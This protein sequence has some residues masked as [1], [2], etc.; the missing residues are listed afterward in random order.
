MAGPGCQA[1]FIN[2]SDI[3]KILAAE[4]VQFLLSGEE[5]VPLSSCDGKTT[6]LFF[7]ASWC[8][9]CTNSIPK[10]VELYHTL[11]E[12]REKMEILFISFDHNENEFKEHF[13]C[14]PWLAVPFDVNLNRRLSNRYQVKHIPSLIPL[15]SEEISAEKDWIG[16]I[17]DYGPEA[18]PF[19]KRRRE[20]LKACDAAMLEGGKLEDLLSHKGRNHVISNN[21]GQVL[22][23][24]LVGKTIGLYFG[25]NWCPPCHTFTQQLLEAYNDLRACKEQ[26]FEIIFVST[27][28]DLKEFNQSLKSMP[29]LAIPYLDK[30]RND[31]CRIFDIKGIPSLVLVGPDG[32]TISTNG[33]AII[34]LYG[35]MA[36]PFTKSKLGEVEAALRKEGDAL[37]REVKDIKHEHLLKLDNAKA[38]L[39]DSC[40]MRGRFWA[41]SC[42]VCDY[43]LHPACIE[44]TSYT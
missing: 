42:D 38:Y 13:K 27:D 22:V 18:F 6:C 32:K 10:L 28:R 36:F 7:S 37:P 23:A 15:T 34:S 8:R 30:T 2:S 35:A 19:T 24:E 17:E 11:K 5:Q 14:M 29:W 41:F 4:Q 16:L 43:D 3:V 31:L 21:G 33:R 12:R 39:C 26:G 1:E 9:A 40:K 20:E 44:E 25:A